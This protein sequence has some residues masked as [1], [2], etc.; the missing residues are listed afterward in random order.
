MYCSA[1]MIKSKVAEQVSSCENLFKYE[2]YDKYEEFVGN[3]EKQYEL[4]KSSQ[5]N[6][7]IVDLERSLANTLRVLDVS[8]WLAEVDSIVNQFPLEIDLYY[9]DVINKYFDSQ[10][11]L[12]ERNYYLQGALKSI[13]S[14]E[15]H[16]KLKDIIS[17]QKDWIRVEVEELVSAVKLLVFT[18]ENQKDKID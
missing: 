2:V 10:I 6:S 17:N 7:F 18:N 5:L 4:G 3:I 16:V 11:A 14:K 1:L 12:V 13:Y 9:P 8:N 15:I